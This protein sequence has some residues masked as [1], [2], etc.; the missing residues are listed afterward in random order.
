MPLAGAEYE[1]FML[2]PTV[3]KAQGDASNNHARLAEL[4]AL[5]NELREHS[6]VSSVYQAEKAFVK[7]A[8]A[9]LNGIKIFVSYKVGFHE[10]ARSIIEPFELYGNGRIFMNGQFPFMCER[11][12]DTGKEFRQGIYKALEEAHWFFLLLPEQSLDRSWT[13]FEAGYFKRAMGIE[14]RLIAIHHSRVEMAGPLTDLDAVRAEQDQ[15]STF[16]QQ[17]LREPNAIPGMA[18]INP[19]VP[20]ARFKSH[21]ETIAAAVQPSQEIWR[22]YRIDYLDI[23]LAGGHAPGNVKELLDA[24]VIEA[25]GLERIFG[26][27]GRTREI[28]LRKILVRTDQGG[29]A[30]N[31]E[32][33]HLAWVMAS[34]HRHWLQS[35]VE[36]IR[37]AFEERPYEPSD[38]TI[39]GEDDQFYRPTLLSIRRF[40]DTNEPESAHIAFLESATGPIRNCPPELS[41]LGTVCRMGYRF[42]WEVLENFH[43]IRT[44]RD[45]NRVR[46]IIERMERESHQR[47]YY[48]PDRAL[49]DNLPNNPVLAAFPETSQP[50]LTEI[51]QEWNSL[52]NIEKTGKLDLA[53]E[54]RNP[55]ATRECL[56]HL[57]KLN[58]DFMT[59]ATAR[60]A[61]LVEM[62]WN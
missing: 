9:I 27:T 55:A 15:V 54:Q 42:K 62:Y 61:E 50:L 25:Q 20:V 1:A 21:A 53:F 40:V 48:E 37:A 2:S 59:I 51:F 46:R 41:A 12:S 34:A 47:G 18:P 52:R 56:R 13:L 29:A 8:D 33:E 4:E 36:A 19:S 22:Q 17:L 60:Y 45:V 43:G 58:K 26:Y 7:Y 14:D 30:P 32:D 23:R 28:S 11:V 44:E 6:R 57:K 24:V 38:T 31:S 3:E 35:I 10:A 39:T 49:E 16:L 5:C